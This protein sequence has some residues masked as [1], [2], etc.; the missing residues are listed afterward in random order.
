MGT[1]GPLLFGEILRKTN[2]NLYKSQILRLTN[3]GICCNNV[4]ILYTYNT[5]R[6]ELIL[7]N[8]PSYASLYYKNM[9]YQDITTF[10]YNITHY[11]IYGERCCGTNYLNQ[12][13]QKNLNKII[14]D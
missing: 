3:N 4:V 2:F 7:Y 9:I 8:H 13:I 10:N 14:E 1:T 11:K 12:L 5:Y 6:K